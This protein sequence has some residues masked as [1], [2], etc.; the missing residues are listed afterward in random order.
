MLKL[1][2]CFPPPLSPLLCGTSLDFFQEATTTTR[3]PTA[4]NN[5]M[6]P[7]E[8]RGIS[9]AFQSG[10]SL[11]ESDDKLVIALDF[12]TTFS[13][14][15]YAFVNDK[16]PDIISIMDWPGE[17][18]VPVYSIILFLKCFAGMEGSSQPK[19]PTTISYDPT[20]PSNFTW[21]GQKH[22]GEVIKGVKLL[23]DP[24]Q[25]RPLYLPDVPAKA[26]LKRL[27]KPAVDIAADFIG[28][29]YKHAMAKI[30]S[31]VPSDYIKLCQKSFVLTV[32]AVWSD[33]AKDLTM[34]VRAYVIVPVGKH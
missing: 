32:P 18:D 7:Q 12:G 27:G 11:N 6:P 9:D 20:N 8:S 1:S 2:F 23:L 10:L 3:V 24:D 34:K 13:G 33:K 5:N 4:R 30:E 29:I 28:A 16:N 25:E 26:D 21:G 14:I 15:A 19:V 31:K 22:K 17:L